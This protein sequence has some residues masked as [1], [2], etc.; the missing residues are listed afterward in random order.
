[1]QFTLLITIS[2]DDVLMKENAV[3]TSHA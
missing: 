1:V 3:K 2:F